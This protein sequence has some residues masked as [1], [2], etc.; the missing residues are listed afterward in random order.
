M[1]G[2]MDVPKLNRQL[3]IQTRR[4]RR[5][6]MG[7]LELEVSITICEH[8]VLRLTSS[9]VS[10]PAELLDSVLGPHRRPMYLHRQQLPIHCP[11]AVY[12]CTFSDFSMLRTL[13]TIFQPN[14]PDVAERPKPHRREQGKQLH[15]QQRWKAVA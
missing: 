1:H 9:L 14:T 12:W 8:P 4:N 7:R 5:R 6:I 15:R 3:Q 11:H 13:L 2:S 10:S